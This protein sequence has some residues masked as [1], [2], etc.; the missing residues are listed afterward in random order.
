[1]DVQRQQLNDE[2]QDTPDEPQQQLIEYMLTTADNPFNPFTHF[3]DWNVFDQ[4]AGHHTSSLLARVVKTSD[5]LSELEQCL[6]IKYAIDEIVK[7][8]VTGLYRMVSSNAEGVLP[9]PSSDS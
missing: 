6:A 7:E 2:Q 1:M 3:D 9:S 4:A 5:E 8:N